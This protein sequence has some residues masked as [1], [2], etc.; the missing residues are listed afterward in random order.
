MLVTPSGIVIA[1]QVSAAIE[2]II[3][4]AGDRMIFNGVRN[5]Q[6]H[7]WLQYYNR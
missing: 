3:P 2:G 6:V 7:Q 5:H 1:R 4:D